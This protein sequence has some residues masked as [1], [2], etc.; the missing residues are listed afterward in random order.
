MAQWDHYLEI[1]YGGWGHA[2][3]LYPDAL[4]QSRAAVEAESEPARHALTLRQR[5]VTLMSQS[6]ADLD[7]TYKIWGATFFA[8]TLIMTAALLA[9]FV[10][11]R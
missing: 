2:G 6:V 11:T 4:S 3:E 1:G 5:F 9:V 8:I 7:P 10:V